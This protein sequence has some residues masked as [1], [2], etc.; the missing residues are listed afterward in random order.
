MHPKQEILEEKMAQLCQAL[1]NHLE[2]IY[3]D[4]YRLH[5]NR[6]RRGKGS[7]PSFDGLFSTSLAFTLGYGSEYGRGYVVNVEIRT[8][9]KVS[10]YDSTKIQAEAFSFISQNLKKFIPD[11]DLKIVQDGNLMKVIGDFSLGDV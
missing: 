11:Q 3:G 2:D 9:D 7:N 10:Q 5:P 6:L 8:L 1:D 4:H